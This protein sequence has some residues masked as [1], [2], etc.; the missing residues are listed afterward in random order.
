[1]KIEAANWPRRMYLI[2]QLL[3][4]YKY[5]PIIPIIVIAF[6]LFIQEE[7]WLGGI[8]ART[9]LTKEWKEIFVFSTSNTYTDLQEAEHGQLSLVAHFFLWQTYNWIFHLRSLVG[10]VI[11]SVIFSQTSVWQARL[12]NHSITAKYQVSLV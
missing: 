8:C 4:C 11:S 5:L 6:L 9:S 7:G 2:T 10:Q 3:F 12:I 1:M